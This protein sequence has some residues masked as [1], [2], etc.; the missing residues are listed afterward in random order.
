[1]E[2]RV[3]IDPMTGEQKVVEIDTDRIKNLFDLI[4]MKLDDI[5]EFVDE[6]EDNGEPIEGIRNAI[7]NLW[8]EI[9]NIS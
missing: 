6:L 2:K 8:D 3:M 9:N 1:M 5:E 7:G 4:E